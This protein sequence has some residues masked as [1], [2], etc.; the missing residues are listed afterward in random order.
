[1]TVGGFHREKGTQ[2]DDAQARRGLDVIGLP[3]LAKL[4]IC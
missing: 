2:C 4:G 1:M 3:D